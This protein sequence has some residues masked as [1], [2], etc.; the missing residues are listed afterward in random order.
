MVV[1][2]TR[3]QVFPAGRLKLASGSQ[4]FDEDDIG[5]LP[6]V[7]DALRRAYRWGETPPSSATP[8]GRLIRARSEVSLELSLRK[9]GTRKKW[10]SRELLE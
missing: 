2:T 7:N 5:L 1:D 4:L 10:A 6:E 8:G 3:G 9:Y